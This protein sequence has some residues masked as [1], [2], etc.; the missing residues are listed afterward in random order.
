MTAREP[1]MVV[2]TMSAEGYRLEVG[3]AAVSRGRLK[4]LGM[5]LILTGAY[6][7]L[8]RIGLSFHAVSTFA[9][10]VWPPSGIALAALLLL[11]SRFWPAIMLGAFLANVWT[12]APIPI[13]VAIAA[14]N[15]GEAVFAAWALQRIPGFRPRL[16]RLRD[17]VGL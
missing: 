14:G 1:R 2:P 13:A 9:T 4:D 10:L 17:V 15:T 8:A 7:I 3:R 6:V 12:G 16:D 11:G 5:G